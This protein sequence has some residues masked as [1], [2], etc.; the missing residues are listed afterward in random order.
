M[1]G[2]L[3][4]EPCRNHYPPSFYP[5]R[6][7]DISG[8][9][10][11]LVDG[12]VMSSGNVYA[13]ISH[14]WG[15]I[16]FE[17]L[18]ESNIAKFRKG[19]PISWFPAT[20]RDVISFAKKLEIRHIWIDCYCIIQSGQTDSERLV[21]I[22]QMKDVYTNS[23][24]NLAADYSI[25]PF[26][27]CV[28]DREQTDRV[29]TT[30][31]LPFSNR[32]YDCYPG[33]VLQQNGPRCSP[34]LKRAWVMQER[35][36]APRMLHFTKSGL[37]WECNSWYM[38]SDQFP[39]GDSMYNSVMSSFSLG[40]MRS[41]YLFDE[42]PRTWAS[43]VEIYS[44]LQLSRP[45]E[46]KL[47]A[48]G[49]IAEQMAEKLQERMSQNESRQYDVGQ[50]VAGLFRADL[51]WQLPWSVDLRNLQQPIQKPSSPWR[52]PSWSWAALDSPVEF[53]SSIAGNYIAEIE[54]IDLQLV[55]E[56]NPY[57][58]LHS[59]S[60]TIDGRPLEATIDRESTYKPYF[61]NIE[62][63]LYR[64]SDGSRIYCNFDT[65]ELLEDTYTTLDDTVRCRYRSRLSLLPVRRC[66]ILKHAFVRDPD[67][68]DWGEHDTAVVGLILI[69][70]DDGT[71]GR[72]GSFW[73]PGDQSWGVLFE[74][75]EE[76]L[77][78]LV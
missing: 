77:V 20:F 33:E 6:L 65:D 16:P 61:L 48:L 3:Q 13:T 41:E 9:T 30:F 70:R 63:F 66:G 50:Y 55:D 23:V 49:G 27:G 56:T 52:A 54:S 31:A 69:E 10:A 60:M 22:A 75:A 62:T 74:D 11:V 34:L 72:A 45:F 15:N 38:K 32:L 59:A 17:T 29:A 53:E 8:H 47:V 44:R 46:D 42:A 39:N 14:C 43:L 28:L 40:P 36:L 71:C 76:T 19:L 1:E 21:H 35:Q 57:G 5:A 73:R 64:L 12:S 37:F 24:L 26:S 18:T 7:L 68:G 51:L 4:H 2:D 67:S 78:K 25:G 58:A